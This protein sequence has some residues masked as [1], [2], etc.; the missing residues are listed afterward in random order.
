MLGLKVMGAVPEKHFVPNIF[1]H[2]KCNFCCLVTCTV[3]I[4]SGGVTI[5]VKGT[6]LDSVQKPLLLFSVMGQEFSFVSIGSI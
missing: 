6:N 5:T 1:F 3:S 2:I 4:F